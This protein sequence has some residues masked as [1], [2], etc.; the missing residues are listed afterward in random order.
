MFQTQ[1]AGSKRRAVALLTSFVLH[2][3]VV[4]VWLDRPPMF[5]RPSSVAWGRGGQSDTLVYLTKPAEGVASKR[6]PLQV[7]ARKKARPDLPEKAEARAGSNSGSLSQG[8][9][10]GREAAPALPIVFPDPAIYPWQLA[11]GLQGDVIVEVTIDE[12]GNVT[13]TRVLQSLQQDIDEKVIATLRNW[14]FKPATVDGVAISSRQDVHFHF[15][16]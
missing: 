16:S 3:V 12:Q 10:L 9:A 11:R 6:S 13:E 4:Y 7:K 8:P 15:P 2:C 1:V 5:V 14:R